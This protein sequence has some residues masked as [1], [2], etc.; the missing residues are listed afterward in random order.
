M[1]KKNLRNGKELGEW[2]KRN[3][4][5][6]QGKEDNGSRQTRMGCPNEAIARV[7]FTQQHIMNTV[8]LVFI[9]TE[10]V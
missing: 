8:T 1:H 4:D 5:K 6:Q 2:K 10:E 9:F 3:S 7:A